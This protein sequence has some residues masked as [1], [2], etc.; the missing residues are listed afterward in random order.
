MGIKGES[1]ERARQPLPGCLSPAARAAGSSFS[2]VAHGHDVFDGKRANRARTHG[3]CLHTL[4]LPSHAN[5][6]GRQRRI[7]QMGPRQ[8]NHQTL[9]NRGRRGCHFCEITWGWQRGVHH[10]RKVKTFLQRPFSFFVSCVWFLVADT[11]LF[12]LV[13]CFLFEKQM[14]IDFSLILGSSARR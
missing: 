12:P 6:Q 8:P 4:A 14:L 11:H 9:A 3:R 1:P 13:L 5:L 7:T 10:A 2:A